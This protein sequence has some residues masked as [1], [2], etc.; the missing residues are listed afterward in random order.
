MEKVNLTVPEIKKSFQRLYKEIESLAPDIYSHG[1]HDFARKI[2]RLLHEMDW[3][4]KHIDKMKTEE[5]RE[6]E[7]DDFTKKAFEAF[8]KEHVEAY[9]KKEPGQERD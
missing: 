6:A 3:V 1:Y 4:K 8:R 7:R 5:E 2:E 9:L